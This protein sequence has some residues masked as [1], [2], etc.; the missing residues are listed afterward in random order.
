MEQVSRVAMSLSLTGV[1]RHT[2]LITLKVYMRNIGLWMLLVLSLMLACFRNTN[3]PTYGIIASPIDVYSL[4]E[5]SSGKIITAPKYSLLK[6]LRQ[7]DVTTIKTQNRKSWIKVDYIGRTGWI[8]GKLIDLEMI[9]I[10]Y[11]YQVCQNGEAD[12]NCFLYDDNSFLI[13]FYHFPISGNINP[14]DSIYFK[15]KWQKI[16]NV[17]LFDFENDYVPKNLFEANV[18]PF[19]K[20]ITKINDYCF[21][22][23]NYEKYIDI[24]GITLERIK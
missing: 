7:N 10:K 8:N 14:V 11:G 24:W 13:R 9:N 18:S 3:N 22:I 4:P 2:F 17:L 21:Q 15:G 1:R 23:T 20:T 12:I 6:I 16:E 5:E 19:N